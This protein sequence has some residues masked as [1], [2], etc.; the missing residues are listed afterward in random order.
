MFG[1]YEEKKE[2]EAGDSLGD[3]GWNIVMKPSIQSGYFV[4][5]SYE[6][7]GSYNLD[8]RIVYVRAEKDK[9]YYDARIK[10]II[11]TM[12]GTGYDIQRNNVNAWFYSSNS[13]RFTPFDYTKYT[14]VRVDRNTAN[15]GD[16]DYDCLN[17]RFILNKGRG[18][19]DVLFKQ[20][21]ANTPQD[22]YY[23]MSDYEIVDDCTG[24][25]SGEIIYVKAPDRDKDGKPNGHYNTSKKYLFYYVG[26]G[27]GFYSWV[28]K[29][30]DPSKYWL[31]DPMEIW[32][33]KQLVYEKWY[34]RVD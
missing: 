25:Y 28:A 20:A 17:S 22:V 6:N 24:Q 12:T 1:T 3:G 23:M 26:E 11:N 21:D 33:D 19:F 4:Y 31:E 10:A 9:G 27:N 14:V 30:E 15:T 16:Y 18:R 13:S 7:G 32:V 5:T 34:Y 8:E 29:G 2:L